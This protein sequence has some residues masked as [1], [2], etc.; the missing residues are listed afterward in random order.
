EK[1]LEEPLFCLMKQGPRNNANISRR[2]L[3]SAAAF[4]AAIFADPVN[5]EVMARGV[6]S[7]FAPN[8]F[9]Q[10]VDLRREKLDRRI[11]LRTDHVVMVAAIELVLIA[12]HAV[13]KR[14]G[15]GQATFRQQLE[16]AVNRGKANLGVFLADEAEKLVGREMIARLKKSA[17]N[18]VALVS[19]L[20]TDALQ[21]LIKNFLRFT[22]GFARSGCVI[23]NPCLPHVSA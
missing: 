4:L 12:R 23:V 8:L 20:Q 15:A 7:V 14:N 21:V 2:G 13:R 11:A 17:Q 9:F 22:H 19:M 3:D 16:R 5:L 18:G 6:K 10:L 1:T